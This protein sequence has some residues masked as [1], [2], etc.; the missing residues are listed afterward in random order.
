MAA[1]APNPRIH[2]VLTDMAR[3]WTRL[4]LEAKQTLKERRPTLQLI[5]PKPLSPHVSQPG[6]SDVNFNQSGD[7]A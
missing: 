5:Y 3:T 6:R 2:A 1:D 7:P 4:A